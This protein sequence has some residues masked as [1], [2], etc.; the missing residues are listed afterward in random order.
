MIEVTQLKEMF[1]G[2]KNTGKWDMNAPMLW[3][4]FFTDPSA[5]KLQAAALYLEQ[6]GY[7]FVEIFEP[8][9]DEGAEPYFFLHVE[10]EE[11]HSVDSLDLRNHELT[12][13]AVK[14]G[15]ATY[16]GMDVGPIVVRQ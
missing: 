3:G 14:Q 1:E 9:L 10:R 6:L 2:I 4:Y 5:E 15:L 11:V 7:R 13:F 12:D 8:E 16:D